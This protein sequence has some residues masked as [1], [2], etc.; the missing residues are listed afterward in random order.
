ME[1]CQ[2][3]TAHFRPPTESISQ[4]P[5]RD[6]LG[7]YPEGIPQEHSVHRRP[8]QLQGHLPVLHMMLPRNQIPP[9]TEG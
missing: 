7:R 1:G 4:G 8:D 3:E 9:N 2:P 5:K 6:P